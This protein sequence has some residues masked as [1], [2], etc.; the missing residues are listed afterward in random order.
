MS[1]WLFLGVA[2][3]GSIAAT[4]LAWLGAIEFLFWVAR[5]H[6]HAADFIRYWASLAPEERKKVRAEW[7]QK[8]AAWREER[9]ARRT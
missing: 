6:S 8:R 1:W 3:A 4:A 7:K 5:L 2:I 9:R